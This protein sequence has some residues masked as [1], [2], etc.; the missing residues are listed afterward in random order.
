MHLKA[1][2]KLDGRVHD[3]ISCAQTEVI[4]EVM[5]TRRSITKLAAAAAIFI[6]FGVG[7]CIGRWSQPSQMEQPPIVV[8]YSPANPMHSYASKSEDGFWRQKVFAAIQSK[9]YTQSQF[10][11]TNLFND[12]KQ[13]LKEKY[14]D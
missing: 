3:D 4:R 1:S 7:F 12:Y 8:A 5:S 6:A 10:D 14:Y 2:P 13:H 11:K 9:P